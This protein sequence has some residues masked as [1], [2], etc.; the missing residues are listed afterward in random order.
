MDD[1]ITVEI[2]KELKVTEKDGDVID[3][4]LNATDH[5]EAY[6]RRKKELMDSG[7][8]EEDA[9][10]YIAD[11]PIQLELFY[12]FDQG[13]FAVESE[14]LESSGLYNPYDGTEIP[15]DNLI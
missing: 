7:M 15:N 6:R 12:S 8:S 11:A 4:W 9:I 10:K 14:A 2:E 3:V 5:P 13:L 1:I